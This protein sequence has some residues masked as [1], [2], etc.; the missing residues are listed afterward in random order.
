MTQE[1]V[2]EM[3]EADHI[4][5]STMGSHLK[6]LSRVEGRVILFYLNFRRI[7]PTDT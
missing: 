4:V 3:A 7:I 1:E 5:P 6:I 2:R